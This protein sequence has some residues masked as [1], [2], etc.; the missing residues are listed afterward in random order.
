MPPEEMEAALTAGRAVLSQAFKQAPVE[1]REGVQVEERV[2]L[3]QPPATALIA[4]SHDAL[5]LVVGR[6]GRS[7]AKEL[8]L[9]SVSM[10]CVHHAP[11][12]VVVIPASSGRQLLA[13]QVA[14]DDR[15]TMT[16]PVGDQPD[17]GLL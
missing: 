2:E 7:M 6:R 17:R 13:E 4:A 11:C 8:L 16:G 3:A 14:S 12:P 5:L 15:V 9:G 10:A 1:L